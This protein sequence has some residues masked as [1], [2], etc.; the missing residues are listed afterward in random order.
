MT[1]K[2]T[3][4]TVNGSGARK[5][6]STNAQGKSDRLHFLVSLTETSQY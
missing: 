4:H 1:A 5:D 6:H 3:V 2:L